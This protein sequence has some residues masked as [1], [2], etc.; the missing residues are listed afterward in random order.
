MVVAITRTDLTS[1][2]FR[3]A[4]SRSHDTRAARRMV[5]VALVPEG[6]DRKSAAA[7]YGIGSIAT[8]REV[9]RGLPG[10]VA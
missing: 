6:A 3:A 4:G 2:E 7:S 5:A 1:R 9:L 8:T 10:A